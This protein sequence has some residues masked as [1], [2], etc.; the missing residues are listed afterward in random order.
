MLFPLV[1]FPSALCHLGE[2]AMR[3]YGDHPS[4]QELQAIQ[5]VAEFGTLEAAARSLNL[6]YETINSHL[7][8]LRRKS[9]RRYLPQ[10]IAWAAEQGY[11]KSERPEKDPVATE[12]SPD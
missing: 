3:K 7:D 9:G 5:A 10:L 11:L 12:K 6:S 4:P 2:E 8:S 1:F